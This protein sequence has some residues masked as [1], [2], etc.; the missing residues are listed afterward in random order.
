MPDP[1]IQEIGRVPTPRHETDYRVYYVGAF[2]HD[3]EDAHISIK[4]V[5]DIRGITAPSLRCERLPRSG[6]GWEMRASGFYFRRL[7][8]A[9]VAAAHDGRLW[10]GYRDGVG[11]DVRIDD[12][13]H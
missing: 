10:L 3:G 8:D 5:T 11:V 6:D 13:R 7:S 4:N 2:T 1:T 12:E 9:E